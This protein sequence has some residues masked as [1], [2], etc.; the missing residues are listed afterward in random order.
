MATAKK[1]RNWEKLGKAAGGEQWFNVGGQAIY[2]S[3]AM[4][5]SLPA[6]MVGGDCP[7]PESCNEMFHAYPVN[8]MDSIPFPCMVFS[9]KGV[10][11]YL[12]SPAAPDEAEWMNTVL[13]K[14]DFLWVTDNEMCLQIASPVE[15]VALS[16]VIHRDA[17]KVLK[18]AASDIVAIW[19]DD[20][21]VTLE[22]IDQSRFTFKLVESKW[23]DMTGWFQGWE[24]LPT[25]KELTVDKLIA[26]SDRNGA[27]FISFDKTNASVIDKDGNVFYSEPFGS[28][29]LGESV[30]TFPAK[31][32][33][34][35]MK[36][37]KSGD[38]GEFEPEFD[39]RYAPYPARFCFCDKQSRIVRGLL[40]CA[41]A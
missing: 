1:Y 30:A 20:S 18:S 13:F 38:M 6:S 21:Q 24:N 34:K 19:K 31:T 36:M 2:G 35:L 39:C 15:Q 22:F 7:V 33:K 10:A 8:S 11:D 17:A 14:D 26:L 27:K 3:D 16:F 40:N 5:A 29:E 4:F 41:G 9:L 32:F 23:Q 37:F 28:I 25:L 12:P